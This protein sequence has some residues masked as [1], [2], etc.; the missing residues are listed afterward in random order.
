MGRAG[1]VLCGVG[2]L[3]ATLAV[4]T[5]ALARDDDPDRQARRHELRQQLQAERERWRGEERGRGGWGPPP[6]YTP[7]GGHAAPPG[8]GWAPGHGA[9]GPYP[10]PPAYAPPPGYGAPPGYVPAPGHGGGHRLSPDERRA[11][12]QELRQQRP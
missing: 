3:F 11:L 12:R 4:A 2:V 5:P 1:R 6:G 9:G 10:T 7:G 8:G